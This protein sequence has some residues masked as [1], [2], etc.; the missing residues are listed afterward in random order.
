MQGA[1]GDVFVEEIGGARLQGWC[2]FRE[3]RSGDMLVWKEEL[4]VLIFFA[5]GSSCLQGQ[6]T[7]EYIRSKKGY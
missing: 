4:R 3:A 1:D 2:S 5:L 6:H 7:S